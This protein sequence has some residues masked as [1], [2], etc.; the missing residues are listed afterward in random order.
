M[1]HNRLVRSDR[2]ARSRS[3]LFSRVPE[4]F[5]SITL[6]THRTISSIATSGGFPAWLIPHIAVVAE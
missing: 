2:S 6:S 5:D 3:A 4:R 1:Y